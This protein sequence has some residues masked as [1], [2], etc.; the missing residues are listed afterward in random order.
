[1]D[2]LK[3]ALGNFLKEYDAISQHLNQVF[4][5]LVF[6]KIVETSPL[7]LQNGS[8]EYLFII[9]CEFCFSKGTKVSSSTT[10]NNCHYV[11]VKHQK[12]TKL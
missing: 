9:F 11:N 2:H 12:A 6:E 5:N 10:Y 4:M 7:L 1:M 3:K 8:C